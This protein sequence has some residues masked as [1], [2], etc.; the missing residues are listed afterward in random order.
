MELKN[1]DV[2]LGL[3]GLDTNNWPT[4]MWWD[5]VKWCREAFGDDTFGIEWFC[6]E[7]YGLY[8]S[9]ENLTIF[10]LRWA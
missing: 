5:I 10:A 8:M 7:D 1:G 4:Y 2:S 6:T 3:I 9:E